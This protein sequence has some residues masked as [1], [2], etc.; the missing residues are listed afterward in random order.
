MQPL[1][2][3]CSHLQPLAATCS[4]LQPL[5]ATCS[6]A[7][8]RVAASGCKWLRV[9]NIKMMHF[10]TPVSALFLFPS[11]YHSSDNLECSVTSIQ[12]WDPKKACPLSGQCPAHPSK[13]CFSRSVWFHIS[14]KSEWH[15]TL[16]TPVQGLPP[17]W[18]KL[19][20]PMFCFRAA[21]QRE[22]PAAPTAPA[23]RAPSCSWLPP[24]LALPKAACGAAGVRDGSTGAVLFRTQALDQF[25]EIT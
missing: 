8:T 25:S 13:V 17:V 23:A 11:R 19:G 1:A 5:A 16:C 12:L 21:V 9:A 20:A 7:A 10:C 18:L 4:H 14:G 24:G 3:T 22:A 6:L 2:A 15:F